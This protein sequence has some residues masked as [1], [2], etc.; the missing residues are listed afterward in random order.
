[1][2][3]LP[4]HCTLQE[5]KIDFRIALE[6]TFAYRTKSETGIPRLN[7]TDFLRKQEFLS[8]L[9]VTDSPVITVFAAKWCGYCLRFIDLAKSVD[10]GKDRKLYLVDADSD[11]GSLWDEYN[12]A[13]VPTIAVFQR[14]QIV[15][16]QDGRSMVGLVKGDLERAINAAEAADKL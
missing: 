7:V 3:I 11:D 12:V 1:M 10:F 9:E 14:G 5:L 2:S 6:T 16:R 4:E 15:F 13:I 8:I